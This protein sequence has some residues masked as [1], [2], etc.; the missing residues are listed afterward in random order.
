A[1]KNMVNLGALTGRVT[2]D[3]QEGVYFL[4]LR[5]ARLPFK[6]HPRRA[7]AVTLHA[8]GA[9]P[10]EKH[11]DLLYGIM[12]PDIRR[13]TVLV[14][15]REAEETA[16]AVEDLQRY[17]GLVAQDKLGPIAYTSQRAKATGAVAA[18]VRQ[19]TEATSQQP[20]I[21]L[22]GPKGGATSTAVRVRGRGQFVIEGET[23]D[24]VSAAADFVCLTIVKML[25]GSPDCPDAAACATGGGCGC[26]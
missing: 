14:D 2:H 19:L 3:A 25:C 4:E 26:G 6:A 10:S 15:P 9:T 24:A 13:V 8:P 23:Y 5:G 1:D 12:G 21:L 18:Q 11:K 16:P 17:I 20:I 7:L 22:R